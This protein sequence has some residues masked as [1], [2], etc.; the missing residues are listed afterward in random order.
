MLVM[1]NYVPLHFIDEP[2]DVIFDTPPALERRR[3]APRMLFVWQATTYRVLETLEEWHDYERTGRMTANMRPAH[4]E[5]AAGR[6]SWGVGRFLL[7][8]ARRFGASLRGLLRS[9]AQRPAAEKGRV[10]SKSR[11]GCSINVFDRL[12]RYPVAGWENSRIPA[13]ASGKPITNAAI[14][15]IG[16]TSPRMVLEIA[17]EPYTMSGSSTIG[18][19]VAHRARR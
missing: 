5:A 16:A 4:A 18:G 10:V 12:R 14:T 9:R 7:S 19:K 3:P 2:I 1:P 6:G 11:I 8:R 15:G 13:A 17:N